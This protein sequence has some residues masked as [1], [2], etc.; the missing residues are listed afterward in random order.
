MNPVTGD[1]LNSL[2]TADSTI[3]INGTTAPL[4]AATAGWVFES[5]TTAQS[6]GGVQ[7]VFAFHSTNAPAHVLRSYVCYPGSPTIETWTTVQQTGNASVTVSNPSVWQLSV[8]GNTVHYVWGLRGDNADVD[9]DTAFAIQTNT[10]TSGDQVNLGSQG[11]STE[12]FEPVVMTDTA[13]DEFYGG[14]LWSGSWQMVVTGLSGQVNITAGLPSMDI[15]V[16]STHPLE[17]PHGFF[18]VVAGGSANVSQALRGFIDQGLRQGR[19][20]QPLVT[21]NTWFAYG[22][23][24]DE[25][26]MEAEMAAAANMGV[27][28]F[29]MDAGWYPG[30]DLNGQSDFTPGLGNFTADP[31][32]FPS[33]LPALAA[34]AHSLGLKFGLWVEPERTDLQYVG[35]PGFAQEAWLATVNGTYDGNPT[36]QQVAPL[37]CLS[38]PDAQAWLLNQLTTL[39]DAVQ[40]DYL[41]WDNNFWI[42]CTR[43]GHGHGK[44]DG[45]HAHVQGLYSILAALRSRY[46]AMLI[47]NVSSGGN[48]LDMG[49]L[50]YTDTAWMDDRTGPAEHVRHNLEGLMTIFPPAYLL[51]FVNNDAT[52]PLDNPPDLQLFTRSR[53]PG[54]L[55]LNYKADDL[56][57]SDQHGLSQEYSVYKALRGVVTTA[58]GVLLTQQA[59]GGT[60]PAWDILEEIDPSTGNAIIF[61]YQNDPGVAFTN[62]QPT[63][64]TSDATYSVMTADG[65]A[66]GNA[67]GADLMADGIEI[68]SSPASGAHVLVL[69]PQ[70]V[71]QQNVAG[72]GTPF[73][74]RK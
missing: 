11:R 44:T 51:S 17:G 6:G 71:G 31:A 7:L 38:V 58:S 15:T 30:T 16:D 73:K 20:F 34:Y 47:E 48:R 36:N 24:V 64:L 56:T 21:Y 49:M 52:E 19:A 53:M 39:L 4:G 55:G 70:T 62:V 28:L 3:T 25:Q 12:Q 9:V 22:T 5:A 45:N 57:D 14:L 67:T 69:Q 32:R 65:T 72:A 74:R 2:G 61:A 63:G 68:D 1:V 66:L 26:N 23:T 37:I 46:P 18:G 13:A 10:L 50:R 40:P 27:E 29:V 8:A 43:S 59:Q 35:Q 42:N 33:G 54:I 41:K 60:V